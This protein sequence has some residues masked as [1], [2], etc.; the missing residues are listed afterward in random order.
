MIEFIFCMPCEL[1]A[2]VTTTCSWIERNV[3]PTGFLVDSDLP[4]D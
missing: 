1:A 2:A 3:L 4:P